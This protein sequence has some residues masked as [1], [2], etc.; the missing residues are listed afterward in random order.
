MR[1]V[2]QDPLVLVDAQVLARDAQQ[3]LPLHVGDEPSQVAARERAELAH[4]VL[5]HAEHGG[6]AEDVV[7]L[8]GVDV[9]VDRRHHREELHSVVREVGVVERV[10]QRGRLDGRE[11]VRIERL[12]ASEHVGAGGD[13]RAAIRVGQALGAPGG[14]DVA[15]RPQDRVGLCR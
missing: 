15:H 9:A 12:D 13:Q 5:V 1:L 10:A 4:V 14:R 11:P 8:A 7:D 6:D 2:R 3:V